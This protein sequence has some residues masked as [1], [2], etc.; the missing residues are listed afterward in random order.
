MPLPD[1]GL[2]ARTTDD[3]GTDGGP[4]DAPDEACVHATLG[5]F[6]VALSDDV[7]VRYR[8]RI[9]PELGGDPWDLYLTFPRYA[10]E[11]VGTFPLGTGDDANFGTCAH[12]VIAFFGTSIARGY[13]ADRGTLTLI[14]DP[15]TLNLHATLENVRL[16][17]VTIEGDDLHSVPVPGGGC[18][19]LDRV[20]VDEHFAPPGWTCPDQQYADGV[21]CDCSCGIPD[22]DCFDPSLP[23]AGC[24]AGQACVPRLAPG[25]IFMPI[26]LCA[27]VCD[28]AGDVPCPGT[29]VCVADSAGDVCEPEAARIDRATPIGGTCAEG[30]YVCGVDPRGFALG[31]C[32]VF[33]WNDR[34]CR[35]RCDADAAGASDDCDA[36]AF[37]RCYTLGSRND[38][39]DSFYGLCTPRYPASW[40]CGGE[41]WEDGASCDCACGAVDPDCAADLPL[42]GC[43]TGEIC[44]FDATCAAVPANDTCASAIPLAAGR[45]TGTTRGATNDYSH[46]RGAGGCIDVEEDAPDVVYSVA[47]TAGQRLTVTGTAAHNI[48]LYLIGPGAPSVCD[49]TSTA[50]VAGVE[51]TGTGE[52][53]TLTYT[54]TEAGTYYLVVDAFFA[55]LIGTHELDVTLE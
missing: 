14:E 6:A 13:L 30:A 2:D 10:T 5:R 42:R 36:A 50:C 49:A 43:L 48:A 7:E 26:T 29:G 27:D 31:V 46:V 16:A 28:R 18:V 35:P 44:L 1:G 17:E 40:T 20:E 24:A 52:A 41:R 23:I 3:G 25:G 53:E 47:L 8:A 37:E 34:T 15:F 21:T 55:E 45:T 12:C 33:D 4:S 51:V 9:S 19:V 38:D 54:A 11:Y 22:E 32:D 39:P